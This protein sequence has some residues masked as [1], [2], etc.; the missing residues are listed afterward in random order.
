MNWTTHATHDGQVAL[1]AEAL[2]RSWTSRV[3][4]T[5]PERRDELRNSLQPRPS[6]ETDGRLRLQQEAHR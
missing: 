1:W 4:P 5:T 3:T 2:V 6:V